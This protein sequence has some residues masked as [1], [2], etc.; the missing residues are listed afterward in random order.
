MKPKVIIVA[1][2]AIVLY[3]CG[4]SK[5]T[6]PIAVAKKVVLSPE[7]AEGKNLYENNCAKC[8]KLYN[9]KDFTIPEWTPILMSM[10]KNADISDAER[11]KIYNYIIQN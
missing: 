3:S 1:L 7:L 5:S 11:D 9:P 4:G 10:Q 2:L 6:T 8:H